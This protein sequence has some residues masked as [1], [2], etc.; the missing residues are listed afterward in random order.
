MLRDYLTAPLPAP[1]ETVDYLSAIPVA[2]LNADGNDTYG[3]CVEAGKAHNVEILTYNAQPSAPVNI[4]P[5]TVVADYLAETGGQ[6][7]GLVIA[8]SLGV[9]Q[10]SGMPTGLAPPAETVDKITAHAELD[11]ADLT[12]LKQAISIFGA[13]LIGL[14]LPD[15][16]LDQPLGQAWALPASGPAPSPDPN[17][18]H[19]V[20][21]GKY[22]GTY[23]YC[24]TWG[25]VTPITP[26]FLAAY[27]DEAWTVIDSDWLEATGQTP[28]QLDLAQL[29]TDLAA[30][31]SAPAPAPTPGPTGCAGLLSQAEVDIESG[32]VLKGIEELF[33]YLDCLIK[34]GGADLAGSF[35]R[36]G[37]R[38]EAVLE[39][40]RQHL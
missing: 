32:Q 6:D 25:V 34:A 23:F 27:M 4:P 40:V 14:V 31:G 3:D 18:G 33:D 20:V 2:A 11:Y 38:A 5:A 22:D 1:P 7:T 24:I 39:R 29:Q 35:E 9:W 10:A 21:L 28:S 13:S 26:G 36:I 12:E 19:C 37:K 16:V 30:L 8:D 15:Y 17:N